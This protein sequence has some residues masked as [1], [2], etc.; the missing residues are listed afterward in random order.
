MRKTEKSKSRRKKHSDKPKKARTAY[1]LFCQ[2]HREKLMVENPNLSFGKI[3]QMFGELWKQ[4]SD[5]EKAKYEKL[6]AQEKIKHQYEIA[7]YYDT[8]PEGSSEES[9]S[10]EEKSAKK[11]RKKPDKDAPHKSLTPFIM[12]SKEVRPRF[13]KDYPNETFGDIGKRVGQRWKELSE[14]EKQEY[15]KKAAA[16][17]DRYTKEKLE[18]DKKKED[19]KVEATK[20]QVK[21]K[22]KL[23]KVESG[24]DSDTNNSKS[25]SDT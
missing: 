15:N 7:A 25:D 4:A 5:E 12:F 13:Q 24:S 22:K 11:K 21:P 2:D 8:H 20:Q 9:E 6:A 23:Q 10:E 19:D 18:Y 1:M 16:D 3:G 14:D 17:K